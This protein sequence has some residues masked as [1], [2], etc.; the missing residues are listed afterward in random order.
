M[1][2]LGKVIVHDNAD[3]ELRRCN[4]RV[5]EFLEKFRNADFGDIDADVRQFNEAALRDGGDVLGIYEMCSGLQLWIIGNGKQT[6][7]VLP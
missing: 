3:M 6:D 1:I 2:E 7:A 4:H 5:E